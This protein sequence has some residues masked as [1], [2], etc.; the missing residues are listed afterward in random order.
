QPNTEKLIE[1]S[2][3]APHDLRPVWGTGHFH[4]HTVRFTA[5]HVS[6]SQKTL[7]LEDY[8]WPEPS[9]FPFHSVPMNTSPEPMNKVPGAM[10]GILNL[11]QGDRIDWECHIINDSNATLKFSNAVF[12]GEMCNMFGFFVP[13]M[14]AT[15]KAVNP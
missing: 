11:K 10:S 2:A 6:G 5:W 9:N 7:I 8:N 4:A 14:G 13:G 1:G 12:T 3:M 15:W